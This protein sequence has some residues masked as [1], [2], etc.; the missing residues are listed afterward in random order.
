MKA[1]L[2]HLPANEAQFTDAD[3]KR[4]RLVFVGLAALFRRD[5]TAVATAQADIAAGSPL[6]SLLW[7]AL[8]SAGA[9]QAQAALRAVIAMPQWN[10]DQRLAQMIDLSMV[11]APTE[12]T[13]QFLRDHLNDPEQAAQARYGLGSA[14]FNLQNE[15]PDRANAVVVELEQ[16]FS[17]AKTL[18]EQ[19]DY[20][21]ALGNAGSSAA[22]PLIQDQLTS[23]N[24]AARGCRGFA[25]SHR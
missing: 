13:V 25:P 7:D 14:A 2:Q 12:E 22:L 1:E 21:K 19:T 24:A 6:A 20:L 15:A 23:D 16:H 3:R 5:Q 10:T 17:D 8:G 9:P 11:R 4:K 18:T